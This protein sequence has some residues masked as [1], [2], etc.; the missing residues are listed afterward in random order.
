[1]MGLLG[2]SIPK[3]EEGT[4]MPYDPDCRTDTRVYV[5]GVRL[6][7]GDLDLYYRKEGP[8]DIGRYCEGT[9]ASPRKGEDY[10]DAFN[11]LSQGEQ[12][13]WD[14]LRVDVKDTATDEYHT[15][16]HGL[17]TGVGNGSGMEKRWHFRAQGPGL[18]VDRIPASKTFVDPKVKDVLRYIESELEDAFP[19]EISI[20]GA[21]R[22]D[23]VKKYGDAHQFV[24]GLVGLDEDDRSKNAR[25]S[26]KTFKSNRKTLADVINWLKDKS[27]VRSWIEP[28]ERGGV[29]VGV[30]NPTAVEHEAHYLGGDVHVAQ[31]DALSELH[32]VNTVTVKGQTADSLGTNTAFEIEQ[33]NV[34]DDTYN[35]AKARHVPLYERAGQ[36]EYVPAPRQ[37]SDAQ[38]RAEVKNEAKSVLKEYIDGTTGGDMQTLLTS[39][40]KPFDTIRAQ[41]TC[42]SSP[43][44]NTDPITYEVSRVHHEVKAGG[45]STTTLNVGVHTSFEDIEIVSIDEAMA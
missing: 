5:N 44:S 45:I 13:E 1:M 18:L 4:K 26:A 11:G 40:I 24:W 36:R 9:F 43:A 7:A 39:P 2:G 23:F 34:P 27:G 21:A 30:N 42:D 19:L 3:V 20:N 6:P 32:P 38:T 17:V 31:N 10:T 41:P 33:I 29:L 35:Y 8:L 14:V 37:E 25:R 22:D 16:F 28:T 12:T 15:A